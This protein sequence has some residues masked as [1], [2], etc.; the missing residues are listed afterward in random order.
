MLF[1]CMRFVFSVKIV[2]FI[3][4]YY[5][6]LLSSQ[7]LHFNA[8]TGLFIT[9]YYCSYSNTIIFIESSLFL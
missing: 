4:L 8:C 9:M 3:N 5:L 1:Y 7:T 6:S 2:H